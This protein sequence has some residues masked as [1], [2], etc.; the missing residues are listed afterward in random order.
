MKDEWEA[1]DEEKEEK[2]RKTP[3]H[4]SEMRGAALSHQWT[5]QA[6][7]VR[8]IWAVSEKQFERKEKVIDFKLRNAQSCDQ[9]GI[10]FAIAVL[11]IETNA[12]QNIRAHKDVTRFQ[13]FFDIDRGGLRFVVHQPNQAV[14]KE[15]GNKDAS[16]IQGDETER[17]EKWET[18]GVKTKMQCEEGGKPLCFVTSVCLN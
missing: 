12:R 14:R 6:V 9:I 4:A 15:G 18:E 13:Q 1:E 2:E 17:N 11:G 5:I 7:R 3:T 16:E 10:G 8:R